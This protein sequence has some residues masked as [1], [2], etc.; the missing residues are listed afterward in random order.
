MCFSDG[1]WPAAADDEPGAAAQAPGAGET[2]APDVSEDVAGLV[3]GPPGVPAQP[4]A[5]G[6]RP[7]LQP[8]AAAHRAWRPHPHRASPLSPPRPSRP[9]TLPSVHTLITTIYLYLSAADKT[10]EC[11]HS[12]HYFVF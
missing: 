8:R 4:A 2:G 3:H 9:S 1:A 7:R 6:A 10:N 11:K 5:A 12:P